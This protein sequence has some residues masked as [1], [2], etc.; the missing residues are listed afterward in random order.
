[1]TPFSFVVKDNPEYKLQGSRQ[2]VFLTVSPGPTL[3]LRCPGL[4]GDSQL[5]WAGFLFWFL[6]APLLPGISMDHCHLLAQTFSDLTVG[7]NTLGPPLYF[8]YPISLLAIFPLELILSIYF[9]FLFIVS[10]H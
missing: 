3:C 8:A 6:L 1:M 9:I 4:L 10:L 5:H 7:K 2:S